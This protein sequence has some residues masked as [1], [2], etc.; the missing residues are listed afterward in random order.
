[1]A[2]GCLILGSATPPVL[3]VIEDGVNGLTVDFFDRHRLADRIDEVF[4]HPDRMQSLREA[5]RKSAIEQYDLKT[6]ALP[7]WMN[8]FSDLVNG[9]RPDL[10]P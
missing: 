10:D 6:Q 2:A 9:N 8:L 1:M 7:R 3:E 5:A 4:E